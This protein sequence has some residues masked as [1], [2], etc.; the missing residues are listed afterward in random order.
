MSDDDLAIHINPKADSAFTAVFLFEIAA[1]FVVLLSKAGHVACPLGP[2]TAAMALLVSCVGTLAVVQLVK[3]A[4]SYV[5]VT[6]SR[7]QVFPGHPLRKVRAR[8]KFTDQMW[9][10]T[11]HAS[12]AALE[13]Y[14]L[15]VED[16]VQPWW[17]SPRAL[18]EPHPISGQQNKPSIH[19]LYLLQMAIW[20]VT[21]FQ[22][23]FVEEKHKDYFLM[24][25]HHLVTIALVGCSYSYNYLRVGVVVL[26][27]HDVSDVLGDLTKIF[28]YCKLEGA[29]GLFLLEMCFAALLYSWAYYRLYL[30]PT[31]VIVDGVVV[32]AREF[33][34]GPTSACLADWD[35]EQSAEASGSAWLRQLV[36]G[37]ASQDAALWASRGFPE[38]YAAGDGSFQLWAHMAALPTHPC[39]ALYWQM[40]AL[41]GALQTMQAVWYAMFIRILYRVV[42]APKE[43]E[44]HAV[45]REVYEGD[46]DDESTGEAS[47]PPPS[48]K[49][50][51]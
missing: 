17:H 49:S 5:G 39:L 14:I 11:I 28:N 21:C 47:P 26:Y 18:W 35:R 9:Q 45:G 31:K 36:G 29:R 12:M 33:A 24:F 15:F 1:V 7:A 13:Y 16:G 30:F 46:S 2:V 48:A 22:H 37:G 34:T 23:R 8:R 4:S 19:L 42:T 40:V 43:E 27:L 32:G 3:R 38:G 25:A 44:I 50:R 41:L 20:L 51:R 10:L 6:L